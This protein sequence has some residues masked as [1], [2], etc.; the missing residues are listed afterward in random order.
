MSDDTI[1]I[2]DYRVLHSGFY[3]HVL[4]AGECTAPA[5]LLL[6]GRNFHAGVWKELGTLELLARCGYRALAVDLP[7]H[8][9][10][11]DIN[12]S[13]NTLLVEVMPAFEIERP[14]VVAPS[15]AGRYALP[16]IHRNPELVSGFVGL[17]PVSAQEYI[18]RLSCSTVRSLILWGEDDLR[19]P[20]SI[21]H[22]LAEAMPG[23]RLVVLPGARHACY[24]DQTELFHQHLTAFLEQV[25]GAG[26]PD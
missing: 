15:L 2:D 8:G 6:H 21:G 5:V 13:P 18:P 7:G 19:Y 3:L 16:L 10:S 12:I 20:V 25:Y 9:A 26:P 17:A 4:A 11:D 1:A 23:G 22:S 24:L 14:V